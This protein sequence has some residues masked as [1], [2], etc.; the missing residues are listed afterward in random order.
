MG[1]RKARIMGPSPVRAA[2]TRGGI[3]T[4]TTTPKRTATRRRRINGFPG[5]L[6]FMIFLY[7]F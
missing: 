4:T 3:M 2:R 1:I 7:L 5:R 6:F